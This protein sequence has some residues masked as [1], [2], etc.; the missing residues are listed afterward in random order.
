[1]AMCVKVTVQQGRLILVAGY[2]SGHCCLWQF[3]QDKN[4]WILKYTAKAHSQPIL[5]I[6]VAPSLGRYYTSAADAIIASY[7]L[8]DLDSSEPIKTIETKHSGQQSLQVRSDDKIL[9]TAGWDGR[10]RVYSAKA[11]RELAVL[12]WHKQGCYALG[13]ADL[14]AEEAEPSE[15]GHASAEAQAAALTQITGSTI[16]TTSQRRNNKAQTTHWI[17]AGSKDGKVSLWDIY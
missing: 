1:M 16:Q 4:E 8:T 9:A 7:S 10:M 13:F 15:T 14:I 12:K 2:E 11:L 3:E 17:A 6:G 5:S